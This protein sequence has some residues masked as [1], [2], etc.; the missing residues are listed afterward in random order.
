M[1]AVTRW[2]IHHRLR[3]FL[4]WVA[5]AVLTTALA[6]VAGR[7]YASN[8]SLPGTEAQRV[9]DLLTRE[10]KAQSGDV[11]TIVFRTDRGTV[12]SPEIRGA[13]EPLLA[14]ISRM[15]HV[16]SVLSPFTPR[17]A[18]QVS[19]DRGTAFAV[20]NYDKRANLLPNATGQPVLAAIDAI[21]VPGL[22]VA[23]GGQVIEQA[24]GF[25]VGPATTVGVIAAL[26]ILLLTFGSLTAA[27]MP[28]V[29]AG[30]GLVTGTAL[31]GLGTHVTSMANVAPELALMIGLGVGIDYALF[32]VTRFRENY[33]R[34]GDVSES[35]VEAMDTSGR[36]ILLAGTTVM[37]ALL[38]M[39][40][41]GVSFMYGLAIASVLAVLLTMLASL[42]LLPALLSRFGMRL[43]RPS[44]AARRRAAAAKPPR[45]SLWRRWSLMVQS[46]PWPLAL[47]SLAVM[48]A[49]LVPVLGLRLDNSDA[50]NDPSGTSTLKAFNLLAQGFGPGFNGP[51]EVVAELRSPAD[52]ASLPAIRAAV[53]SSSDVVAVTPARLSPSGKVAVFE[54]YPGSAPQDQATT[55]LVNRLRHEVLPPIRHRTG[56]SILVGGFTA[57]S[58]DFASVLSAKLPLFIAVVVV[59]SALLLFVIFR[60]LVIPVQAA[61]M[62]LLSIGGALGA[63]VLVFQ[64][65]FLAGVLGI[66][67]GPVEPWVPV[68]MFAVVFG[69]SMDYEVFLVSRVREEWVRHRD[70][71]IAVVNGI[72]FT[73]RVISAAA[74]IMICVFLSFMVG[75]ERAVKEFGFGLAA[76][77]F[78]DA[79]VVRCVLLPAVLELLGTVTWKLPRRLDARLPRINIEGSSAR[80]SGRPAEPVAAGTDERERAPVAR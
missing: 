24:E 44:R 26:I 52:A 55:D 70:A 43:V 37:I 40:A 8:F 17:G 7:N 18:L 21:H 9:L 66:Q 56:M 34:L 25:S 14:Q 53:A 2:V 33:G 49:F 64:D 61:A 42:T 23:A 20:V 29:T 50:G 73:G 67:K 47:A 79:L 51:L 74:A 4:A 16:V 22:Q 41:T 30:F 13:I 46:R 32:I 60:S 75:D 10:F 6:N 77:V 45:G 54:A 76:A 38:G 28:L 5:V 39:F 15:P 78:L 71:S 68:L 11:D 3:V 36:A 80:A 69:L 57:G 48:L 12:D 31:I 65:G 59:L 62:N 1:L 19:R 27:G 72:A 58:I 35:I 63:T